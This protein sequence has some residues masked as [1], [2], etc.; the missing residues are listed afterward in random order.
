M[1]DPH[2]TPGPRR[3]DLVRR[4]ASPMGVVSGYGLS[5]DGTG[6]PLVFAAAAS[7]AS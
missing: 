2:Q 5:L 6:M 4:L 1:P 3:Q 7:L